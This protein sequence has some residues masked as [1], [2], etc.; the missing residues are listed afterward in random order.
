MAT[1]SRYYWGPRLWRAFHL[2]ANISDRRDISALWR[3]FLYTSAAALPCAQCKGHFINYLKNNIIVR[4]INPQTTTGQQFRDSI[5]TQLRIFHNAVNIRLGKPIV[6]ADAYAVLYPHR[7][8]SD[9]L[10][11]IQVVINEIKAAWEPL[12]HSSIHPG[13][14]AQW[15][16]VFHTL[17][18]LLAGGP[19]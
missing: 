18:T 2:M 5:K 6:P 14:Y 10:L 12:L 9:N 1:A 13:I 15:K 7:T 3:Q 11:E 19:N 8:R 17:F 16:H 4:Q